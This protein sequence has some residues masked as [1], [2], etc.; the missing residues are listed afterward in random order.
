VEPPCQGC[1]ELPLGF[2]PLV[3]AKSKN[4]ALASPKD[5]YGNPPGTWCFILGGGIDP[6]TVTIVTSAVYSE[7]TRESAVGARWVPY[8]PDCESG[9]IEIKT[10]IDAIKE[11]EEVVAEPGVSV[12]FSFVVS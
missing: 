6:S 2:T 9:Q 7:E 1:G 11:E 5:V 3:A 8:A 12:P 10:Y 4:V